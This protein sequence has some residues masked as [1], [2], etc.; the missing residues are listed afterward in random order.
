MTKNEHK[1]PPIVVVLGHVDHGKTTLLDAIR[2]TSFAKKE[3]G[4]ITQGIGASTVSVGSGDKVTF[5][6]TPGHAAFTKMRSQGAEVSDIA[7][8]V[9][10]ADDGVKPQTKEAIEVIRDSKIPYIIAMT[11]TDLP[12]ASIETV[13]NQLE[14]EGILMEGRGGDVPVISVSGKTG[15]GIEEL[16]EMIIL[17]SEVSEVKGDPESPMEAVV[18]ETRKDKKGPLV[19]TVT[20]NGTLKVGKDIYTENQSIRVKG[21]FD[22]KGNPTKKILPGEPAMILGF[23]TL[24]AVGS[25]IT[26]SKEF[27]TGVQKSGYGKKVEVMEGQLPLVIKAKTAGS[28]EAIIEN[29]PEKV[30]ALEYSEGD[31]NESDIFVAKVAG[32]KIVAFESGVSG[33]VKKLAETEGV[34]IREYDVIYKIFEDLEEITKEKEKVILGKAKVLEIFPFNNKKVAGSKVVEGRIA[35]SDSVSIERDDKAIGNVKIISMKKEKKDIEVAK[36]GEEFGLIFAPQLDFM[37]GDVI[38]SERN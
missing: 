20:R 3:A 17:V 29:L 4:G 5:I 21:L 10:A 38:V 19:S 30:V 8:L 22:F 33:S 2:K 28:L 7:V 36:T 13:K 12:T 9:I 6:D 15:K 32:A 34:E 11:K 26:D 18:I 14:K 1:R 24:P 27:L 16:L 31:V 37:V 25:L 35:R 23:I